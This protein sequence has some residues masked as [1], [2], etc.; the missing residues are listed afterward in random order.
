[1]A[2]QLRE[3]TTETKVMKPSV[4]M[5]EPEAVTDWRRQLPVLMGAGIVL[6]CIGVIMLR[7]FSSRKK[8]KAIR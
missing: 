8:W 2:L 1:M 6:V 7:L 5:I 3:Q 4:T